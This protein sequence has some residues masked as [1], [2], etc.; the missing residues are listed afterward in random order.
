MRGWYVEIV[1]YADD[2][3]EKRMG[4]FPSERQAN[5]VDDG[6]NINLD[7]SRFYTRTLYEIACLSG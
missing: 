3:V 2:K 4:P 5:R 6:A 7:H 1:A